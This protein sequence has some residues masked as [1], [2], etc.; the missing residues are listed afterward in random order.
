MS[1]CSRCLF[2]SE[3]VVEHLRESVFNLLWEWHKNFLFYSLDGVSEFVY[4]G[5]YG[6]AAGLH[7]ARQLQLVVVQE[8]VVDNYN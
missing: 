5:A 3:D 4:R 2:P 6:V 7:G 8:R 1:C